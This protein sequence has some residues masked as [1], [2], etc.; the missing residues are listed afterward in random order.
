ML[1]GGFPGKNLGLKLAKQLGVEGGNSGFHP[2]KL[3]VYTANIR[4][5]SKE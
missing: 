5:L 4:I 1:G 3:G 2:E